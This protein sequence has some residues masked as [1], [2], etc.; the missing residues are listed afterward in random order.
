MIY[1]K[2]RALCAERGISV[3]RLEQELGIAN[4]TIRKWDKQSP[5]IS[6]ILPVADY[7]SIT[8]DELVRGPDKKGEE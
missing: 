3:R 4:A 2:V 6:T 8:L 7:F 1:E 5:K